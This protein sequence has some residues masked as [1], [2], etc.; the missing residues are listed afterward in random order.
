MIL[1]LET[2]YRERSNSF[3]YL[4]APEGHKLQPKEKLAEYL[5]DI[6]KLVIKGYP[7]ADDIT[8]ET[9]YIRHFIKGLLDQQAALHIGMKDPKTIEEARTIL[10]TYNSLR[11]ERKG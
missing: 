10:E 1:A 3:S 2:H 8:R 5:S 7:T 4:A 6:R 9:I 11:D